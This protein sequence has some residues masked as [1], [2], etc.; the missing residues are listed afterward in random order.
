MVLALFV[1]S[2]VVPTNLCLTRLDQIQMR[3][4]VFY[5]SFQSCQEYLALRRAIN[6]LFCDLSAGSVA[7]IEDMEKLFG[8]SN[9]SEM[10][11]MDYAEFT[12]LFEDP[13]RKIAQALKEGDCCTMCTVELKN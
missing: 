9:M 8:D 7:S 2:V 5:Q 12:E 11:F 6:L 1:F 3:R 4:V 13:D 10:D